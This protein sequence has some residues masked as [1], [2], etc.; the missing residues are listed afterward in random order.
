V[1]LGGVIVFGTTVGVTVIALIAA[2]I[3]WCKGYF[4]NV[5]E[6]KYRMMQDIDHSTRRTTHDE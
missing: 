2:A 1:Y 6:A 5:E 4:D 3:F